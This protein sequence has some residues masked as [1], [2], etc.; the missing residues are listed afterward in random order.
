MTIKDYSRV[1]EKLKGG[2]WLAVPLANGLWAAGLVARAG[3]RGVTFGYFF[4]PASSEPPMLQ[5]VR[6]L[7]PQD[8]ILVG[9]YGDLGIRE[10][11]WKVLG[12]SE[13]WDP[14]RWPL[15][16]LARTDSLWGQTYLVEYSESD[17]SRSREYKVEPSDA[18][19]APEDGLMGEG[20]V[21][22]RLAK[23]LHVS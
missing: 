1:N 9:M 11:S 17:L 13:P 14:T 23:L 7:E 18:A 12:R 22:L 20:F 5:Q 10:G 3:P 6:R 2:E 8:A 15:V 19:G 4:G 16:R 21:R